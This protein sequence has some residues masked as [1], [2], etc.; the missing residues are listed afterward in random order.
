MTMTYDPTNVFA[1]ILRGEIPCNKVYEDAFALAFYD[2][3]PAAPVHILVIPKGGF[4]SFSDFSLN[5]S[6]EMLQGFFA[7]VQKIAAQQKLSDYRL[8]SN[9]GAGAGQTVHH[10]HM[11]IL[12]GTPMD[13]LLPN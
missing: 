12:A 5:A 4:A 2:I 7:A 6:T 13:G 8:I 10:F 3:A 1:K 9:N 11:H